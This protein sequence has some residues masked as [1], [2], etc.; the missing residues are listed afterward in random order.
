MSR[1]KSRPSGLISMGIIPHPL[2]R[3]KKFPFDTPLPAEGQIISV[4]PTVHISSHVIG[5]MLFEDHQ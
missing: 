5:G 1:A 4:L 2:G 3:P